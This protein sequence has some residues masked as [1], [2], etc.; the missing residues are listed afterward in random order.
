MQSP[1]Q[2]DPVLAALD[3][4][5][6]VLKETIELNR[7]AIRRA[8]AIRRLR[9]RGHSYS[10]LIPMEE[11]PLIIELLTHCLSEVSDASSRFRKAEARALYSEG[12]TMSEIA[13]LFGVTRQR[14]AALLRDR[15]EG[16]SSLF[17]VFMGGQM[18]SILGASLDGLPLIAL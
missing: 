4:L 1:D 10:E 13:S 11:R 7:A 9:Q 5:V 15:R 12:L 2:N 3:E 17:I 8:T 6:T 18:A 14:V 16:F